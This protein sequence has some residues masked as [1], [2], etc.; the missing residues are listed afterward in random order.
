MVGRFK[1]F[2]KLLLNQ[3]LQRLE[4]L[5]MQ[6][7]VILLENFSFTKRPKILKMEIITFIFNYETKTFLSQL[8]NV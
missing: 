8:S 6:V 2:V 5:S 4:R 1:Y 3:P 7:L